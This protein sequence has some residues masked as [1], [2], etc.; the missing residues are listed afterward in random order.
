MVPGAIVFDHGIN[1]GA[2]PRACLARATTGGRPYKHKFDRWLFLE[3]EK[4]KDESEEPKT[5]EAILADPFSVRRVVDIDEH[6]FIRMSRQK[7]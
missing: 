6:V 7:A 1:V 3:L 4:R 5:A 2:G